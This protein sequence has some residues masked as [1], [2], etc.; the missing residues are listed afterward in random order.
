MSLRFPQLAPLLSSQAL[1]ATVGN[2]AGLELD[3]QKLQEFNDNC[4]LKMVIPVYIQ[5][6][7]VLPKPYHEPML[8]CVSII[9]TIYPDTQDIELVNALKVLLHVNPNLL[10][11]IANDSSSR[12]DVEFVNALQEAKSIPPLFKGSPQ[13]IKSWRNLCTLSALSPRVSKWIQWFH[14]HHHA[15]VEQA[16]SPEPL[17]R[18]LSNLL[19]LGVTFH[20]IGPEESK[21]TARSMPP[22]LCEEKTGTLAQALPLS[23]ALRPD[24]AIPCFRTMRRTGRAAEAVKEALQRF[25]GMQQA[26]AKAIQAALPNSVASPMAIRLIIGLKKALFSPN[27]KTMLVFSDNFVAEKMIVNGLPII[28][29][30][31]I[32][33]LRS[34]PVSKVNTDTLAAGCI[35]TD[36]TSDPE[37]K[38]SYLIKTLR[39]SPPVYPLFVIYNISPRVDSPQSRMSY[40]ISELFADLSA[41]THAQIVSLTPIQHMA[42]GMAHSFSIASYRRFIRLIPAPDGPRP[43]PLFPVRI[44]IGSGP[45]SRNPVF[46]AKGLRKLVSIITRY[47]LI[48]CGNSGIPA[49]SRVD[50]EVRHAIRMLEY[51]AST[52]RALDATTYRDHFHAFPELMASPQCWANLPQGRLFIGNRANIADRNQDLPFALSI[53]THCNLF[54]V[55]HGSAVTSL[56]LKTLEHHMFVLLPFKEN[57]CLCT[58]AAVSKTTDKAVLQQEKVA[59]RA[60]R[61]G[62]LSARSTSSARSARSGMSGVTSSTRTGSLSEITGLSTTDSLSEISMSETSDGS[63]SDLD[64][65]TFTESSETSFS[66][67]LTANQD[68]VDAAAPPGHAFHDGK[69][70]RRVDMLPPSMRALAT[71]FFPAHIENIQDIRELIGRISAFCEQPDSA[72]KECDGLQFFMQGHYKFTVLFRSLITNF[73]SSDI[74]SCLFGVSDVL[75]PFAIKPNLL[76]EERLPQDLIQ[77][78]RHAAGH[79]S[80]DHAYRNLLL[81]D[82]LNARTAA[83]SFS[84]GRTLWRVDARVYHAVLGDILYYQR[85]QAA[86]ALSVPL[87]Q[88]T[89]VLRMTP[90]TRRLVQRGELVRE[91]KGAPLLHTALHGLSLQNASYDATAESLVSCSPEL[92]MGY[93]TRVP[94]YACCALV[95]PSAQTDLAVSGPRTMRVAVRLRGVIEEPTIALPSVSDTSPNF[96]AFKSPGFSV[97]VL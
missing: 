22:D 97:D 66:F 34:L 44:G 53:P 24:S 47:G 45:V 37:R 84:V 6:I 63:D 5:T 42:G 62:S 87:H 55:N 56:Y 40:R 54:N 88:I 74:V 26:G 93:S 76:E 27:G 94:L 12:D 8:H 35:F 36:V 60:A 57:V 46:S 82:K 48:M 58:K 68:H 95:K 79:Q 19:A 7:T 32:P 39:D 85:T 50:M 49:D 14:T 52:E 43:A 11:Q 90:P 17:Q 64:L 18:V 72:F 13:L 67:T 61:D 96:W 92:Y 73:L 51:T 70:S 29:K 2:A 28:L 41:V 71:C 81:G 80:V 20:G 23:L 38:L 30:M 4:F 75:D 9:C 16:L 65:S 86:A 1:R 3:V 59:Q 83:P 15:F 25:T 78:I 33:S 21:G 31:G 10:T 77:I 89:V 69:R 91:E